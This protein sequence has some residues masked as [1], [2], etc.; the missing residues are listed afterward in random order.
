V[1]FRLLGPVQI[2]S[3]DGVVIRL[4]RR[5]ERLALS[6]LL[7]QPGQVV[8]ADRLIDVLWAQAPPPAAKAALHSLMSRIRGAL[9]SGADGDADRQVR[10]L[11][12]SQG[13]LLQIDPDLVDLHRFHKLVDEARTISDPQLR[14]KHLVAALSLW[15]GPALADTAPDATREQLCVALEESRFAAISDRIDA[16]LAAGRHADLIPELSRLVAEH[17][18]REQMHGQLMLALYRSGRRADALNA[19]RRARQTLIAEVGLEPGE[20]LRSL[21]AAIIAE[22]PHLYAGTASPDAPATRAQTAGPDALGRVVPAQLPPDLGS[23]VGRATYLQRLDDLLPDEAAGARSPSATTFALIVGSG[24][25]GKTA[26]AAHWAQ[27]VRERFPD[28]QLYVNLRGFDPG[29][30]VT[31]A[32][33]AVRG[34]LDALQVPAERIPDGP[35]AQA[36]LYRSLLADRRVLVL[37]DNAR[38][39]DQVR[40]LLP[41]APGCLVVVTSRNMLTSLIAAEGAYPLRLDLLSFAESLELLTRRL[42]A[43]RVSVEP[44]A[45]E[46]IISRC[47]RL[48][49]A[50]AIVAARAAANPAFPLAALAGEL[51]EARG[52]LDALDGGDAATQVRTVLSWSYQTLSPD[53]ARLFRLLG[54]HP[55]PDIAAS[56]VASLAGIPEPHVR[57]LL[58][59]LTRAHLI[60][61]VT[62]SRYAFH[63]L[64]RAYAIELTQSHDPDVDQRAAVHRMLDHYLHTAHTAHRLLSPYR[65]PIT[66]APAQPRV[67]AETLTPGQAMAWFAA[68]HATLLAAIAQASDSGFDTHSWQ[69]AWTVTTYLDRRGHWHDLAA[70]QRIALGAALRLADRVGQAHAH[71]GLGAAYTR[72]THY[73]DARTH[74][75]QAL[76]LFSELGDHSGQA[77]THRGLAWIFKRQGGHRESLHHAVEAL[78]LYRKADDRAGQA[79][80][81]NAVGWYHAQLGDYQEALTHCQQALSAL[82]ELH[83]Q[84]G[85]ANTWDSL[86]YAHHHLGHHEQATTCYQHATDLF[87]NLGDRYNEADTLSRLGETHHAANDHS[88]ARHTWQLA[89]DIL[90][91]LGHPDAAQ[92][93]MKLTL[94]DSVPTPER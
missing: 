85:E 2:R 71:N 37:L 83:D 8:T 47:A 18:F 41:G 68:E 32:A 31:S 87:R 6:V 24:G 7:L 76:D 61:E 45:A 73:G 58:A 69:L 63:D 25:V 72:L 84:R 12:L 9:R 38:D 13:Y 59:E 80:T 4:S 40:P 91:E 49:L 11:T 82:K 55:G 43:S 21:E 16:D 88:T 54:L 46:E 50:L 19:Y 39:A 28:G 89:L 36:G 20:R 78:D 92:I 48:P 75:E 93:R 65:D 62:P 53:V 66:L 34:F 86:G 70:T 67:T 27:R 23:F 26:L 3:G 35:E 17:P 74:Y 94:V 22:A 57:R 30:S 56:A 15:R 79:T 90:N 14:S 5:K 81:L 1:E 51:R 42:G 33:D 10:L 52:G 29:G 60:T 64:L 77:H 44:K